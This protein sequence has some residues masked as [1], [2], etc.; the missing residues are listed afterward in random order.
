MPYLHLE[1]TADLPENAD[2]PDILEALAEALAGLESVERKTVRAY[3]SLRSVWVVGPG[4]PPGFAHLTASVMEG[5]TVEWRA[6]L[7]K[8]LLGALRESFRASLAA[9]EA[10]ITVEIREIEA[11]SYLRV[12]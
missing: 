6:E 3:H 8:G 2:V 7:S 1:T 11:D 5:K 12:E 9:Q 10:A 4:A